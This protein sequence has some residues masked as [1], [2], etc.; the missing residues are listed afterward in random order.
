[1]CTSTL[2]E[3][4][5]AQ[6]SHATEKLGAATHMDVKEND[7]EFGF[8][9]SILGVNN[10][11]VFPAASSHNAAVH[12]AAIRATLQLTLPTCCGLVVSRKA[13][14]HEK[15]FASITS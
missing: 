10:F 6:V 7:V 1:M 2:T 4:C 13:Q 9:S 12:P 11:D 5:G 15:K 3:T 14:E 8:S